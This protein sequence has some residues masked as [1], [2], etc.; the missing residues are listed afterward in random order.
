MPLQGGTLLAGA[1]AAALFLAA[2]PPRPAPAGGAALPPVHVQ[3][4]APPPQRV[5][6]SVSVLDRAGEPVAGLGRESFEVLEDGRSQTLLD[7]GVESQRQDRPLSAVVLV[8]RSGSV[9]QQLTRWRQACAALREALRPTDEVRVAT[10][11]S[12]VAIVQ[13]FTRGPIN[14]A[15]LEDDLQSASGGTRVFLALDETLHDLARRPG[16]KAIFL[17]T[18]GLDNDRSAEWT[19]RADPYIESLLRLAVSHQVTVITILPG[20]TGRGLLAVQDFA[21]RTGGWW[22]YPGDDLASRVRALGQRL[23]ASY[24]LT[25]DSPRDPADRRTRRLQVKLRG[26]EEA[27]Y[28]V[29]TVDGVFGAMPLVDLLREDLADDDP[30]VRA[31]A[32][33]GLGQVADPGAD[34]P[35]RKALGDDSSRVRAAAAAALGDRGTVEAAR[36]LA[37]LL[38]DP[39]ASVREAAIAALTQLLSAA[40]AA[41]DAGTEEKILEALEEEVK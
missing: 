22:L 8:D 15:L 29:R 34:G 35:L 9:S 37:R 31:G 17:M 25:Y 24:M 40:R 2:G 6:L 21:E 16:R 5:T 7:F 28:Q 23:L 18:D 12:E 3:V 39:D 19:A 32:A 13:D 20:P 26:A 4:E 1:W 30:V 38:R 11:T 14:M 33:T 41:G 10:F 36:G 27:G